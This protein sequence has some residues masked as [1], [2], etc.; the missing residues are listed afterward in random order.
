MF[1]NLVIIQHN[2]LNWNTNKYSLIENYLRISPHLILINSHG[3][4]SKETLKIPGYKV[5]KA[6]YSE[7]IA[8]G[9][10]IAIKH[11]IPHKL[12]DDFD[13]DVLPVE[14]QTNLGPII[15]STMYLP[16]RRPFLPFTDMHRL[17]SNNIPTYIIGDFNGRHRH[18]KWSQQ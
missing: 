10:A 3:Q 4:K 2:V 5:Y 8:D 7:S 6:N 11:N 16:P 1:K 12:Y 17:L 18:W 13:F 9:S 15:I 14:I